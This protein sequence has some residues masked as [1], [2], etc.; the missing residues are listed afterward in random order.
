VEYLSFGGGSPSMA[1]AILNAQGK[2]EPRAE[3]VV[4]ADTG[5]ERAATYRAVEEMEGWLDSYGLP[6][7]VVKSDLGVLPTFLMD[8]GAIPVPAFTPSGGQLLRR[9]THRWK[10]Q[11]IRR[12]IREQYGNGTPQIVQMGLHYGE[13]QRMRDAPAKR[14]THRY[15][16]IEQKMTRAQCDDLVRSVGLRVPPRSACVGCPYRSRESWQMLASESSDEFEAACE[17]DAHLRSGDEPVFLSSKRRP[18][19]QVATAQQ[20]TMIEPEWADGCESGYCWT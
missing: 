13:I 5:W 1:L 20:L 10:V 7:V 14:D 6:L 9:C 16:L 2:V 3:V 4:F 15:P 8:S 11:P 12:W 18:L 17:V 19:H